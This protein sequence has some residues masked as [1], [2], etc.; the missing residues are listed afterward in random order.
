[1]TPMNNSFIPD[2]TI[3]SKVQIKS[4]LLKKQTTVNGKSD[5]K[6]QASRKLGSMKEQ[7]LDF[8]NLSKEESENKD[9]SPSQSV[10]SKLGGRNKSLKKTGSREVEDNSLSKKK[11]S[12]GKETVTIEVPLNIPVHFEDSK[13]DEEF[14]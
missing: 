5:K 7:N 10:S 4:P 3:N 14:K 2:D 12:I 13:G 9:S 8:L 1:M 11:K 6:F